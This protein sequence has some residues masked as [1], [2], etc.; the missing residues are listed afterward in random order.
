VG[1][2]EKEKILEEDL[3]KPVSEFLLKQGYTVRSEVNYCDITALKENELI[4]IELKRNLSVDLLA[5]AVKRQ[6]SADLVYI[7]VPKPKRII[8]S[9][10]WKDIC[11]LIRRLEMGLILVSFKGKQTFIEVPIEPMYFDRD[12]SK[13]LNKKKKE[14]IIK[15]ING[16]YLDLNVGGSTRKKLV[17]AYR[18]NAIFIACCF[19]M[20]G[21]LSPKEL[22]SLGTDNKK[23]TAILS[24]NHYGWFEKV[25]RGMYNINDQGKE[26]LKDYR[27][28]TDYYNN[29]ISENK[30]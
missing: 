13:T 8:G 24:E 20:F 27:E 17:T 4:I 22:R 15:E 7:A 16:R 6:K 12:K 30:G 14:N 11:H 5:Q 10:K 29:K 2:D 18:E 28:L 3:C 25:K 1:N 19:N 23:T 9:S 21:A 26:A